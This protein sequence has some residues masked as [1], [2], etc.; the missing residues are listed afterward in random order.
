MAVPVAVQ[1]N[2]AATAALIERP[3][4]VLAT[5]F[6]FLSCAMAALD[7]ASRIAAQTIAIFIGDPF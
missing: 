3:A 2:F 6:G 7:A 4:H 5:T 1:S